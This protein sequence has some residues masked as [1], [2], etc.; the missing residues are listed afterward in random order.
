MHKD[1]SGFT[2][3]ELVTVIVLAAILSVYAVTKWPGDR[4]LKLPAQAE[5]FA[6]HLQHIQALAMDWG[7]SLRLTVNSNGYSVS[8]VSASATPPCDNSPVVDPSTNQAFSISL[9]SGLTL[10]GTATTDF[11]P[12]GRPVTAGALITASPARTFTFNADGA[13]QTVTLSPLTGFAAL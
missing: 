9:E 6:A 2:L 10:S 1:S 11:D 3:I 7:Q 13:S 5:L 8:C 4:A 12:L